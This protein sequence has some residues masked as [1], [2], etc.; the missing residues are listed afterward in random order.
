MKV[1]N[2]L[3][4]GELI[5]SSLK[6]FGDALRSVSSPKLFTRALHEFQKL[7]KC[8]K[9]LLGCK[10]LAGFKNLEGFKSFEG[11]KSFESFKSF[12]N[13]I[14]CIFRTSQEVTI[15]HILDTVKFTWPNFLM[16]VL[17]RCHIAIWS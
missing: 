11:S 15:D 10:S 6:K 2:P 17:I 8:F 12:V 3:F 4:D 13:F 16:S 1:F 7:Q 5:A 14:S 9:S